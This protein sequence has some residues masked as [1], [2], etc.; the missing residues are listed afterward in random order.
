MGGKHIFW[1]LPVVVVLLSAC[2]DGSLL[3]PELDEEDDARIQT[4]EDGAFLQSTDTIPVD[5]PN[6]GELDRVE[7]LLLRSDGSRL[8]SRTLEGSE[9]Q[10]AS[11]PPVEV[12][13]L[14]PGTYGIEFHLYAD[15]QETAVERRTFFVA[16]DSYEIVGVSTFPASV[17]PGSTG[18]AQVQVRV[19]E[20]SDPYLRWSLEGTVV[21]E[22]SLSAGMDEVRIAAPS[23]EGVYS[24]QVELF[25][26]APK[27]D[28]GFGFSSEVRQSSELVVRQNIE[29]GA[30]E[31][32]PEGSYYSLFHFMGN[33]RDSGARVG[34]H[35]DA[36]QEV[37]SFG[38]PRFDIRDKV[39]GYRLDGGSGI[40]L[41]DVIIPFREGRLT[42]FSLNFRV[43]PTDMSS[44]ATLFHTES[45]DG[46]FS[47]DLSVGVDGQLRLTL[48]YR[49]ARARVSSE[50]GLVETGE[51]AD[52]SVGVIPEK[53][54][55]SVV[56]YRNGEQRGTSSASFALE[57]GTG[58]DQQSSGQ[59]ASGASGRSGR[60]GPAD[61]GDAQSSEG[62]DS[63]AADWQRMAGRSTLGAES[64][65]FV[66]LIDEFGVY[67]RDRSEQPNTD[68]ELFR[69]AASEQYGNRLV[70]AEGFEGVSV[71]EELVIRGDAAVSGSTLALK[72]GTTVAFPGFLFAEEAVA[73]DLAWNES[74][75]GGTL[76][77]YALRSKGQTSASM[78]STESTAKLFVLRDGGRSLV[79]PDGNPVRLLSEAP[80]TLALRLAHGGG[81][82]IVAAAEGEQVALPLKKQ[83]FEGV[84]MTVQSGDVTLRVRSVLAYRQGDSFPGDLDLSATPGERGTRS[85]ATGSGSGNSGTDP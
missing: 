58:K 17:Y 44:E 32:S 30:K 14:E 85:A 28:R 7:I 47:A 49:G 50:P 73:M 13:E 36:P 68:N 84:R 76:A 55:L 26:N 45:A 25:P 79:P 54:T 74:P 78:P 22:G 82:L 56:W 52:L 4:I 43:L 48:A 72:P 34:L 33:T 10:Q 37:S 69:K 64:G 46:A 20:Q 21:A 75:D 53:N 42:P 29:L 24:V 62:G 57:R 6:A 18:I 35:T 3:V 9:L 63:E 38:A 1:L 60:S 66:G 12:P 81:E 11:L 2:G 80:K 41:D 67:F 19:P 61:S 70:Y 83:R 31:L 71:P 65:G 27:D 8:G 5:V 40:A 16:P 23:E 15:G 59:D 51:P 77:F 39:F